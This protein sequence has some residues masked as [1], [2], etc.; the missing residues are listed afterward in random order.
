MKS[1][2]IPDNKMVEI[3]Q[4]NIAENT[5]QFQTEINPLLT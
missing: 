5:D 3:D 1:H 2:L 4:D